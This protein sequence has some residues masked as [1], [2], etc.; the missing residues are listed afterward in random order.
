M[1]SFCFATSGTSIVMVLSRR[2]VPQQP[3]MSSVGFARGLI[4]HQ[5]IVSCYPEMPTK[6][7]LHPLRT[8]TV[9]S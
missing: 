4:A 1:M 5:F 6:T 2:A 9:H 7:R 8:K 3:V